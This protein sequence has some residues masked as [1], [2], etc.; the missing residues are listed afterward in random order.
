[1]GANGRLFVHGLHSGPMGAKQNKD[2]DSSSILRRTLIIANPHTI[3]GRELTH[4]TAPTI[5]QLVF[6]WELCMSLMTS[7]I[8]YSVYTECVY[9]YFLVQACDMEV[10]SM[11]LDPL[12]LRWDDKC[13]FALGVS[14]KMRKGRSP[15]AMKSSRGSC[16]SRKTCVKPFL[17]FLSFLFFR[18][19]VP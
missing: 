16:Q 8:V 4:E 15:A 1:M 2:D 13:E 3:R 5:N 9:M 10:R 18:N 12:P 7:R 17:F 19:C 14:P 11:R 6:L